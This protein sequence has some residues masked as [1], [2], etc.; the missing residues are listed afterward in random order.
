MLRWTSRLQ[1]HIVSKRK[2][3][4]VW[5]GG[6]EAHHSREAELVT[7]PTGA[8][9]IAACPAPAQP[10]FGLDA[11]TRLLYDSL[12]RPSENGRPQHLV[13]RSYR[14]TGSRGGIS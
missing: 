8:S 3:S 4:I 1:D 9:T 5:S 11:L 12:E 2:G 14:N 6:Y 10:E 7:V 13:V